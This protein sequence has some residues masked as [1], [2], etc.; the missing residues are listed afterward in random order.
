[1]LRENLPLVGQ[2]TAASWVVDNFSTIDI[3]IDDY[4]NSENK[5]YE[6]KADDILDFTEGNPFGEYGNKTGSF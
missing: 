5:F 1:M 2:D 6:D 4:R 3:D